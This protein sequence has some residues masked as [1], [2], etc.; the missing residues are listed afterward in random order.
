MTDATKPLDISKAYV[1]EEERVLDPTPYRRRN[2][3]QITP[4]YW[5]A[6]ITAAF[7]RQNA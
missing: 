4:A 6:R 1:P 2:H 7:Q 5:L 3:R